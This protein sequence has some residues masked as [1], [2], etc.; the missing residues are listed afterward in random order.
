MVS[1][2]LNSA[3]EALNVFYEAS[4]SDRRIVRE[5]HVTLAEVLGSA[6]DRRGRGIAR[7]LADFL[8]ERGV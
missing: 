3:I 6:P 4:G 8:A 2:T 5:R 1:N 7:D